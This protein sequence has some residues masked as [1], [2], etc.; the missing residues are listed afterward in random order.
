MEFNGDEG[1]NMN[2]TEGETYNAYL[3]YGI[4]SSSMDIDNRKLKGDSNLDNFH[5]FTIEKATHTMPLGTVARL[6]YYDK[7]KYLSPVLLF[8]FNLVV[9]IAI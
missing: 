2:F 5:N 9:L 8:I 3:T 1:Y 6:Y 4:F 7:S